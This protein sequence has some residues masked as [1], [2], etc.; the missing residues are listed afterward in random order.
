[1]R[2]G[3]FTINYR[4]PAR[5]HSVNFGMLLQSLTNLAKFN[6]PVPPACNID[7]KALLIGQVVDGGAATDIGPTPIAGACATRLHALQRHQRRAAQRLCAD[8]SLALDCRI[9]PG[10]DLA[11]ALRLAQREHHPRRGDSHRGQS[12]FT[13]SWP[14]RF[15]GFGAS[16]SPWSGPSWPITACR[17]CARSASGWREAQGRQRIKVVF[18]RMLSPEVMNHVLEHP[19]GLELGGTMREVTVLFFGYPR[20]HKNQ[21]EY[22]DGGTGPATQRLLRRNGRLRLKPSG[23]AAQIHR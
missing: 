2:R 20:L 7:R 8:V 5:F 22:R 3:E 6:T 12:S 14:S 11:V 21:R 10:R 9:V 15:S 17:S 19:T 23:Y 1:M 18:S 4:N 13:R 16:K